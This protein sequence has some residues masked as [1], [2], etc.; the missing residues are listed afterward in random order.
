MAL[1]LKNPRTLHAIDELARLTGESKSEAV[2]SAIEARL[3]ELVTANNAAHASH[4][5]PRDLLRAL[6][7]D[8]APRFTRAGLGPDA[9]GGSVDPTAELYDDAGL[10]R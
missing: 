1:N 10:P 4:E 8:S 6:I 5:S 2:A 3:A 7:A 9:Q